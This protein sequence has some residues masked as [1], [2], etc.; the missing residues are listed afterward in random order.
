[1]NTVSS[2]R[3][4]RVAVT[5]ASVL[6][7][8]IVLLLAHDEAPGSIEAHLHGLVEGGAITDVQHEQIVRLYSM[9]HSSQ[10][11]AWLEAQEIAGQLTRDT[12]L[13]INAL[14]ALS[15]PDATPLAPAPGDYAGNGNVTLLGHL[16]SQPPNPYY[17]DNSSTGTLYNGIWGYAVGSQ[18]RAAVQQLRP[19]HR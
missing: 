4:N 12:H 15:P 3:K 14:L 8:S 17:G 9:N 10:L 1:M 5:A 11:R 2:I 18:I 7:L 13:Y 6:A 16:D 19:A